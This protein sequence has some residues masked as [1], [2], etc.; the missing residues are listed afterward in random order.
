MISQC[1]ILTGN[2]S[3]FGTRNKQDESTL[4]S[5][6][7]MSIVCMTFNNFNDKLQNNPSLLLPDSVMFCHLL[8][9]DQDLATCAEFQDNSLKTYDFIYKLVIN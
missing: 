7:I 4:N 8:L 5:W 6:K 2:S 9:Q 1:P 3:F